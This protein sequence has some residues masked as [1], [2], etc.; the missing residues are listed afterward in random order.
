[1]EDGFRAIVERD[2]LDGQHRNPTARRQWFTTAYFHHPDE[3]CDEVLT[4]G[5]ELVEVLGVEGPGA[6]VPDLATRW[7][8][9]AWRE[10]LL[11]AA[12]AVELEPCSA[13]MHVAYHNR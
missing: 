3:L 9:P 5:L 10:A 6:Q 8:D 2:L 13:E 7:E 4:A 11:F 1:M 12:R